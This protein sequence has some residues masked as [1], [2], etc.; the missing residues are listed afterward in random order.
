MAV[1]TDTYGLDFVFN[2]Q[3]SVKT[4][5]RM[6]TAT[7]RATEKLKDMVTQKGYLFYS[8]KRIASYS[9]IFSFFGALIKMVGNVVQLELRLAEVNTLIDK[10]NQDAVDSYN[11][12]TQALLRLDPHLG[13]A[14][15]L[16]KGLYE[17]ISAGVT[18]PAQAFELLQVSA[19]YAKVGL[20]DLATAASSLTAVMKAYGFTADIM[21]AKSDILFAAV[22]EG[23]FHTDELNE[24]I[25]KVL[26]T[27]AAMNVSV[28][29]VSAAL[30][31]MTQR[32][33]DVNEAS[34]SL[35]RML[36][37]FL[38]PMDKAQKQFTKLGWTWGRN[39]F[40]GIGLIGAMQRLETA[41]KRYG[42]LLPQIF[43]RQRAL[44]GA[45]ILQGEGLRDLED[46]YDRITNATYGAG[47]VQR[48]YEMIT[49]T[50]SE[51]FKALYAN[52]VQAFAALLQHKG[53]VSNFIGQL[54]ELLRTLVENAPALMAFGAGILLARKA[55]ALLNVALGQS[56]LKWILTIKWEMRGATA[57]NAAA[58]AQRNLAFSTNQVAAALARVSIYL[59]AALGLYLLMKGGLDKW[60]KSLE[61]QRQ[62]IMDEAVVLK[63]YYTRM[64]DV[65]AVYKELT[66]ETLK[67]NQA[68]KEQARQAV[69]EDL[70]KRL[71]PFKG[72][73]LKTYK[74]LEGIFSVAQLN[75][76]EYKSEFQA[77]AA[78]FSGKGF[79][80]EDAIRNSTDLLNTLAV[81][82]GFLEQTAKEFEK[83]ASKGVPGMAEA[84]RKMD[85]EVLK[86]ARDLRLAVGEVK[87][88][89]G[90]IAERFDKQEIV[91][92]IA[93]V[94][95]LKEGID[96]KLLDKLQYFG[97][98][99]EKLKI[100][101]KQLE[102]FTGA[103]EYALTIF[104]RTKAQ[105]KIDDYQRQYEGS[106]TSMIYTSKEARFHAI[107]MFNAWQGFGEKTPESMKI[108]A[109][110]SRKEIEKILATAKD[111]P[112]E[113]KKHLEELAATWDKSV[114]ALK[115]TREKFKKITEKIADD[116]E[117]IASKITQLRNEYN[118]E[119]YKNVLEQFKRESIAYKNRA[120]ER[121]KLAVASGMDV[122]NAWVE[123]QRSM[124]Q[125]Q[126]WGQEAQKVSHYRALKERLDEFKKTLNSMEQ[127][128][129]QRID[130]TYKMEEAARKFLEDMGVE[131]KEF[132][133]L[134]YDIVAEYFAKI[135]EETEAGRDVMGEYIKYFRSLATNFS[136]M[137]DSLN[138]LAE[139]MGLQNSA[140]NNLAKFFDIASN[141][142]DGFA[143][144][145]KTIK[146]AEAL[147]GLAATLGK[148]AG[149]LGVVVAGFKLGWELGKF[150][151]GLF[152]GDT[153]SAEE[154]AAEEAAKRLERYII[155]L[156]IQLRDLGQI[157][158]D[159]A[160]KIHDL[161][162]EGIPEH[163]ALSM[164]LVDL[165]NDT[166]ISIQNFEGYITRMIEA[167]GYG[168]DALW[169]MEEVAEV[170][171]EAFG[172]L[173][174]FAKEMGLEGHRLLLDFM[175]RAKELGYEIK[176]I[177]DYIEVQLSGAAEGLYKM[178]KWVAQ[179]AVD[180][181]NAMK[182][183]NK[184]KK[185][186]LRELGK[187]QRQMAEL[188]E[189]SEAWEK[190][191]EKVEGLYKELLKLDKELAKHQKT[192]MDVGTATENSLKR[193]GVIAFSVFAAMVEQ[194]VPMLEIFDKMK[195]SVFALMDRYK[196][197]GLEVPRYLRPMFKMFRQF[198]KRPEF[199]EGL[200]GLQEALNG[201]GNSGFLTV[202][203]FKALHQE[204]KR[205]FNM[206]KRGKDE[207]GLGFTDRE[208]I[209][210]MYP[211]LRQMWWYAEQYG[212][213]LPKWMKEA[214][215]EAKGL[216]LKFEKPA[217]ERLVDEMEKF[218]RR[219]GILGW[220]REG[221]RKPLLDMKELLRQIR[222]KG[223]YQHGSTG[224]PGGLAYLHRG[225]AVIP[226][227]MTSALK[228]FFMGGGSLG[229]EDS[230]GMVEAHIY[231]DG[232]RTYKA[233]V[234]YI[235]KGGAYADFEVDGVGVR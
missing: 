67:Y 80:D 121:F 146:D 166:G 201:L 99:T 195:D 119:Q 187:Y 224:V 76:K 175:K 161:V 148:V 123:H 186:L 96:Q 31:I 7:G 179:D 68:I 37:S 128:T 178:I 72:D 20:T 208:A 191:K 120:D 11:E 54:S 126:E 18:D 202:D 62:G 10:T 138:E 40:E 88:L 78:Y 110:A 227:D 154:K 150:L 203:A 89:P 34:T 28:E 64:K 112:L 228:R 180:A 25:G 85:D 49:K 168:T 199:F 212:M 149:V 167:L 45:F 129:Q 163:L 91:D 122:L 206:M 79:I 35:N 86:L 63:D 19:R 200:Q 41:S 97:L 176:E 220:H 182:D 116:Q 205:Y 211:L 52:M 114:D 38:R 135:R 29:E 144:A 232:E 6:S 107:A 16:T 214:I 47:I 46:M 156:K 8:I 197:L 164:S 22:R 157:S 24:A 223:T 153:R 143:K 105:Q 95:R 71:D 5:N 70:H 83:T 193:L 215:E 127:T 118:Q 155:K 44:R 130:T 51:Q 32:G 222:D 94:A 184:E 173:L 113:V 9:A 33:L 132:M 174:T 60:N 61:E 125:I 14:I 55:I 209:Q 13:N 90:D 82:M 231:V 133:K 100:D 230:G 218:N 198:R 177:N 229:G 103:L 93:A 225:E 181:W 42:D 141:A 160:K 59:T 115:K 2:G 235:R 159:M 233:I 158:D 194:G 109:A 124:L 1:K 57:A 183:L 140:L 17:I 92:M 4:I 134:L 58:L 111:L 192:L 196:A 151:K 101:E 204:A 210:M 48:E 53:T 117:K 3:E 87:S 74:T 185:Q 136:F 213:R 50:V 221:L 226:A 169:S 75:W 171:G 234:P 137:S 56:V 139:S 84:L 77:L 216:G 162:K 188:E 30:A 102:S 106:L 172:K 26:P 108:W 21:R 219:N 165:M 217:T 131:D 104:D 170:V 65:A 207:G 190:A 69:L 145:L 36:I 66:G 81:R 142:A 27:A 152:G 43:R 15:D 39:A 98:D 12:V 189:G 23:K 147:T 73:L